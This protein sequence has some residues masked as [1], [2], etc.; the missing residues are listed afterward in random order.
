MTTESIGGGNDGP[1]PEGG[2]VPPGGGLVTEI[3]AVLLGSSA[4]IPLAGIDMLRTRVLERVATLQAEAAHPDTDADRSA[5]I[6][7]KARILN[8]ASQD[9][10]FA[11]AAARTAQDD[12]RAYR[13]EALGIREG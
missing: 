9:L 13:T 10:E 3:G 2:G 8:L 12:I 4:E 1:S 11:Y 7:K 5:M 6:A